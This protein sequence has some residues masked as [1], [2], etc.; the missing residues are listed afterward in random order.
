MNQVERV[1]NEMDYTSFWSENRKNFVRST[2]LTIDKVSLKDDKCVLTSGEVYTINTLLQ[3][4]GLGDVYITNPSKLKN[5][6]GFKTPAERK[7]VK[8]SVSNY[9]FEVYEKTS[10]QVILKV[11]AKDSLTVAKY[12]YVSAEWDYITVTRGNN[13]V[14]TV[15]KNDGSKFSFDWGEHGYTLISDSLKALKLAVID[16]LELEK[17]ILLDWDDGRVDEASI[18]YNRNFTA[19]QLTLRGDRNGRQIRAI[20]R[21]KSAKSIEDMIPFAK[22][23]V[24]VKDWKHGIAQTGIDI[25]EAELR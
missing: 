17:H 7:I 1:E 2:H 6:S 20:V 24:K 3:S 22:N 12:P 18:C 10:S 11:L 9:P 14:L 15:I 5:W 25:W 4:V 16:F 8:K 21:D 23:Y 13:H 19:W